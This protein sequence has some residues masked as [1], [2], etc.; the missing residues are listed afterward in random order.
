MGNTLDDNPLKDNPFLHLQGAHYS[1]NPF[2]KPL[3]SAVKYDY[4]NAHLPTEKEDPV[5]T[6]L[7]PI[8]EWTA[9]VLIETLVSQA[10]LSGSRVL[11]LGCGTGAATLMLP[12]QIKRLKLVT[13]IDESPGMLEVAKYKFNQTN[14]EEFETRV[15]LIL[16]GTIP[17]RLEDYWAKARAQT[18]SG[19]VPVKFVQGDLRN[20]TTL[21]KKEYDAAIANHSL[22]WLGD[23]L[24]RFFQA[25][26]Q[27]LKPGGLVAWNTASDF[28]NDPNYPSLQYGFHYNDFTGMICEKL[29]ERGYTIG[30]NYQF[31]KPRWEKR[32][33]VDYI[34]DNGFSLERT[35]TVLIHNDFQRYISFDLPLMLG[36]LATKDGSQLGLEEIEQLSREV[37]AEVITE[38]RDFSS[39]LEHKYGVNPIFIMRKN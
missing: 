4:I 19:S 37:A 27:V 12:Q 26:N 33:I 6:R 10:S 39:D 28:V 30:D 7:L 24:P 35:R 38:R 11:D 15:K 34:Q 5:C 1:D 17:P 8:Y 9:S 22:H 13:G 21:V 31:R 16:G 32:E 20:I 3:E 23:D 29:R 36:G 14:G 18:A 2:L 25:L